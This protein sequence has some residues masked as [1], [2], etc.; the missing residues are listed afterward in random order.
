MSSRTITDVQNIPEYGCFLVISL[1]WL[2][3]QVSLVHLGP[4]CPPQTLSPSFAFY[5]E[6]LESCSFCGFLLGHYCLNFFSWSFSCCLALTGVSLTTSLPLSFLHLEVNL[7]ARTVKWRHEN[8]LFA[9][10]CWFRIM[11]IHECICIS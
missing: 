1:I 2:T 11:L 4:S 3:D 8:M 7:F 10:S 6:A 5:L 9:L